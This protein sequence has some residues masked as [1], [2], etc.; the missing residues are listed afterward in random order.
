MSSWDTIEFGGEVRIQPPVSTQAAIKKKDAE[1]Q[2]ILSAVDLFLSQG[3][4]IKTIPSTISKEAQLGKMRAGEVEL[5][6]MVELSKRWKVNVRVL[7]AILAKWPTLMYI[8]MGTQRVY[9]LE[10][11]RRCEAQPN[12]KL[13][14]SGI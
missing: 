11:I 2:E 9:S 3:G 1:R 5:I 12:Y 7:P 13:H 4:T 6:D 14:K 8:M 10:D